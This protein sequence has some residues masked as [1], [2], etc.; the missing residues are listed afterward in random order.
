[1]IRLQT[2]SSVKS[3]RQEM[4]KVHIKACDDPIKGFIFSVVYSFQLMSHL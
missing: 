4:K 2:E 1:M 3:R